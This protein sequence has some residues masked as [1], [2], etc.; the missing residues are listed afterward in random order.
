MTNVEEKSYFRRKKKALFLFRKYLRSERSSVESFIVQ[1]QAKMKYIC[2]IVFVFGV[3]V[4]LANTM[5]QNQQAQ[6]QMM[7]QNQQ[8]QDQVMEQNQQ[9]HDHVMEQNQQAQ[10]QVMQQNQQAQD[11]VMEQMATMDQIV[12]VDEAHFELR[13]NTAVQSVL[14][15]GAEQLLQ[16][17]ST[18]ETAVAGQYSELFVV[19]Q[20]ARTTYHDHDHD[21]C[22][23]TRFYYRRP[24][25]LRNTRGHFKLLV[26]LTNIRRYQ[27][28][29][30]AE[31]VYV[32]W[33]M[34]CMCS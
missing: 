33:V 2:Y 9:A 13:V 8:V 31:C 4:A 22:C 19:S 15:R 10:N 20:T 6:D 14:G 12:D 32:F 26:Q 27:F 29:R 7:E 18:S 28:V 1:E 16:S 30:Y 11:H 23:P 17:Y 34:F 3:C 24:L 5:E 25:F 21:R